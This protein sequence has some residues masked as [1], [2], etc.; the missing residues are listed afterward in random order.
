MIV[1]NH[2]MIIPINV[3][4][5]MKR[6]FNSKFRFVFFIAKIELTCK[7]VAIL[8]TKSSGNV[9]AHFMNVFKSMAAFA[10]Y[11]CSPTLASVGFVYAVDTCIILRRFCIWEHKSHNLMLPNVFKLTASLMPWSKRTVAAEWKTMFTFSL[12]ICKSAFDTPI[13]VFEISP[14]MKIIFCSRSGFDSR[15]RSNT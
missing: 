4:I 12:S 1:C 2:T 14:A 7:C 9:S 5:L 8:T 10:G 13:F 15:I 11:T 3:I 6:I